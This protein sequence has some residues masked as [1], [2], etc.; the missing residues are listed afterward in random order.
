MWLWAC[1]PD[2]AWQD[3]D[4]NFRAVE[5]LLAMGRPEAGSL[6]VL[7]EMFAT[8]FSMN[9]AAIAEEGDGPT[10]R[11]LCGMARRW[12]AWLLAGVARL[13][14]SGRGRNEA[15][16]FDPEG[17]EVAGYCKLHGFSFAGEH[18]HYEAGSRIV[19]HPIGG[20]SASWFVCYDLRFPEAF[21]AAA[22]RGAQVLGVIANWPA[23]R[24]DH[25]LTLLKA[26]AIENQAYVIGVNRCG[27]DPSAAY[28]GRSQ[29]IDPRGNVLADAG[30][31][32]GTIAARMDAAD[33]AAYRSAFG[34]LRDLRPDLLAGRA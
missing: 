17:R 9:V 11:F 16:L 20:I 1:Q 33:L 10:A 3:K 4:A 23:A 34:A 7:P 19:V 30:E 27:R 24:Q 32:E 29:I 31:R 28:G 8:G 26:R 5:R 22:V 12:G 6:I 18:E 13:A 2:I 25:W 15:V 14:P 21:R